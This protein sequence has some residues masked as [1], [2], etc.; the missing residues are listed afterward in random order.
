[1]APCLTIMFNH[2]CPLARCE[3]VKFVNDLKKKIKLKKNHNEYLNLLL[4]AVSYRMFNFMY[5]FVIKIVCAWC[6]IVHT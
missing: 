1:M 5:L 6:F 2:V 3:G 4:I